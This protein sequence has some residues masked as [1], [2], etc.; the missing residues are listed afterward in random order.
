MNVRLNGE[1]YEDYKKRREAAHKAEKAY[2]RGRRVKHTRKEA[3][4]MVREMV[5]G[6]RNNPPLPLP[7]GELH[8]PIPSF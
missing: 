7:S 8:T 4:S 1:L 2:L 6:K 5:Q 3:R